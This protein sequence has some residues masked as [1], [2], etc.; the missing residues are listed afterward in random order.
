MPNKTPYYLSN[1]NDT[2][3]IK[4]ELT[5]YVRNWPW[6]ASTIFLFFFIAFFYLKYAS[7]NYK[8]VGKIKILDDASKGIELAGEISSL[9]ESSKVNLE[10]EIEV[11]KSH[12]LLENVVRNLNLNVSY[13]EQGKIKSKQLWV[14]PFKVFAT[15]SISTLPENENYSIEINS[16][17]YTISE[18][19]T[20]SWKVNAHTIDSAYQDL[21]F[22]IKSVSPFL[23][24]RH[25]GKKYKVTFNSMRKATMG[26]SSSLK[27][28]Q[29]GK[30]SDILSLSIIS[31][32]NLKSETIINEII[33]QFNLDGVIDRQLISQRTIDFV[34]DRFVYLTKELDS[35]EDDKRGFKQKNSLSDIGLD[36]Q[37]SILRK[38]NTYDEVLRLETQLEIASL[39]RETL[40][41]QDA[42]SLLPANIGLENAGIN[43][44]INDFNVE[45]IYRSR[46]VETA[47]VNNPI[48]V[49]LEGKLVRLKSNILRSVIAYEKQTKTALKRAS[50]VSSRASGLFSAIPEKEKV[51]RS[52]ERQQHI[53]EALYILL[54]E[55]R[56]EAAINLA[57]TSPSI[58]VV[59]YAI[60]NPI[61]ISPKKSVIY[62]TALV[63]GIVLPFVF[64][65][66]LF[67]M[68]SKIHTK[69]DLLS[70]NKL[71]PITGE[72]P[73]IK[74]SKLVAG[75]S[76]RSVLSEAF[77][78]LRTNVNYLLK[79]KPSLENTLGKVVYVTSAI[80]GE[81]KTFTAVNLALS[82]LGLNKKV[83]LVGSDFRNPQIHSYFNLLKTNS[84]LSNYLNSEDINYK[85]L[86]VDY[87]L[88]DSNLELLLSGN[89]PPNPAEL[90]SNGKFKTLL[91]ELKK[92]YDYIVV[93][94]A[95]TILVT[96]TMLIAPYADAT[97]Y[98]VRSRFT[99]K[100]LLSFSNELITSNR[101]V[102]TSY[103]INGLIPSRLYG[104]NYNYGYNYGYTSSASAIK[105]AWY[106]NKFQ[107]TKS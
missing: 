73:F 89:I 99:D 19:E 24:K 16:N 76:D 22:L 79:N 2:F 66:M 59:D 92:E 85:D 82:Y 68:D 26:L 47:G 8:T 25:I 100:K 28:S 62:F 51:L 90:I 98:V 54:L 9:F 107:K 96:D 93:D 30:K 50:K 21:P 80:K 101:L 53:K 75:A 72:I 88:N 18:S 77:R 65:Y 91:D 106:S 105:K 46:I 81:G 36:T 58:K 97:I 55:K 87:K 38:T 78:V 10:N 40:N 37:H 71:I 84:G 63:M 94:T 45:V 39:L 11:I 35:I 34:S 20:K 14:T 3:N 23:I 103:L 61:P 17:G 52:I 13:F 5:K 67:F 31:D 32:S 44:L 27:V 69:E 104:Y 1:D 95:P 70:K 43:G 41:E 42:F 86:I 33:N 29:I 60:T 49:N 56:E 15:D 12:R 83:I 4:E 74:E 7:I 102:N 48:I 57:V 6:F 64:F